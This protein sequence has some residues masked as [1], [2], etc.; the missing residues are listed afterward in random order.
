MKLIVKAIAA[1]VLLILIIVGYKAY[2]FF[3]Y[4]GEIIGIKR[5]YT[6]HRD[7][8]QFVKKASFG[9]LIFFDNIK[10]TAESD[11]RPCKTCNPP[12][13]SGE[14]KIVEAM[15]E[16]EKII[17]AENAEKERE[18]EK[19]KAYEFLTEFKPYY[20]ENTLTWPNSSDALPFKVFAGMINKGIIPGNSK[21][22]FSN[23]YVLPTMLASNDFGT[24]INPTPYEIDMLRENG[25][26]S[27]ENTFLQKL[28]DD[29]AKH[30]NKIEWYK[31]TIF[32]GK[33]R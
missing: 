30:G 18:I 14:V 28:I 33:D 26:L 7:N 32:F 20:T 16:E 13:N 2:T 10:D 19:E 6:Y 29:D 8:C 4:K 21:L 27:N 3:Y 31:N 23:K 1:I 22:V 24:S 17:A 11:Y 25:F 12:D 15:R 5:T 9:D